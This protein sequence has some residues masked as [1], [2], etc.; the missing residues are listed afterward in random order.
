MLKLKRHKQ[1]LKDFAGRAMSEQHY[2]KYLVFLATLLRR[3][4]LPK[5]A[6][7]H[8]LKGEWSGWRELHISG[9]LLL[10]YRVGEDTLEL[11]RVGTHS[12][13]FG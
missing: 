4:Q 3:Q 13:L 8:P 12:E 2:A 5:E 10:I 11:A 6:L 7:D 9:D 1:F